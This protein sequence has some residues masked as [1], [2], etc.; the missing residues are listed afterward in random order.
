MKRLGRGD[1]ER[2]W[3]DGHALLVS[4]E[5]DLQRKRTW[6]SQS[7]RLVRRRHDDAFRMLMPD[8]AEDVAFWERP[9]DADLGERATLR[10]ILFVQ[11]EDSWQDFEGIVH[12]GVPRWRAM[13]YVRANV[14]RTG[15]ER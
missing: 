14:P 7:V 11:K 9:A 10:V 8:V 12:V 15:R 6:D 1:V 2:L 4:I 3:H 5:R 13:S